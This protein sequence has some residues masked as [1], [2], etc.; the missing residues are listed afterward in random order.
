MSPGVR[1][2][3]EHGGHLTGCSLSNETEHD[4]PHSGPPSS[5]R[6]ARVS[7]WLT[8]TELLP[9]SPA[10]VRVPGERPG[11]SPQRGLPHNVGAR[12]RH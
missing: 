4:A 11:P 5:V 10:A 2:D 9:C 7:P 12:G 8:L 6:G 1:S 3:G